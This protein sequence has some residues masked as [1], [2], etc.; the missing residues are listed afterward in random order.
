MLERSYINITKFFFFDRLLVWTAFI[1]YREMH[2]TDGIE[3]L[4]LKLSMK[5][6]HLES[7]LK[8]TAIIQWVNI[9]FSLS[10][11]FFPFFFSHILGPAILQYFS[12]KNVCIITTI[13]VISLISTSM[14]YHLVSQEGQLTSN[15]LREWF[16]CSGIWLM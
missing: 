4:R 16:F 15:T 9:S 14:W 2:L 6:S 13:K 11:L 8:S 7:W 10:L 5:A 12:L 3:H 1:L